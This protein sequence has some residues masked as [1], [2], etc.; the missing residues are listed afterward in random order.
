[1]STKKTITN[2]EYFALTGMLYLAKEYMSKLQEIET[3]MANLVDEKE[4]GEGSDYYGH[5][6]DAIYS[7]S[8]STDI[9]L[10]KLH[11]VVA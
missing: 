2:E 8:Y 11:I 10:S 1:M 4:D 9:L 6:S 7:G 5:V 3:A